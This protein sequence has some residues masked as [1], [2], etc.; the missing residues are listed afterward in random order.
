MQVVRRALA[1]FIDADPVVLGVVV[2]LVVA[3]ALAWTVLRFVRP[4]R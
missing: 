2:A 4:T 3:L 1:G